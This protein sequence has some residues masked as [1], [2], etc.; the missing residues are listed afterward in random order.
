MRFIISALLP[1]LL[2]AGCASAPRQPPAARDQLENFALEARFALRVN[3]PGEAAQNSAGR[4]SWLQKKGAGRILL[5]NPLG[6]ALA[7]IEN[8]A[9]HAVL[10]TARGEIRESD[11]PDSLL[12]EVTGQIIPV[13]RLPDWLLG[14]TGQQTKILHDLAGRPQQLEEAGWQ[15]DY[16]YDNDAADALPSRLTISRGSAIELRLRIEEWSAAP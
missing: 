2:L 6:F 4:L 10:R 5:S 8:T 11:N 7:E 1:A 15:V 13:Q 16:H 9:G 14:R 3:H 12:E